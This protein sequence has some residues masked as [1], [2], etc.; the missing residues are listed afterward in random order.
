VRR[1]PNPK[2]ADSRENGCGADKAIFLSV[3]P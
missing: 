2:F 1:F 3:D